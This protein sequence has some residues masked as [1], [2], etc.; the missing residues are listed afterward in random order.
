MRG[1]CLLERV[2]DWGS[3]QLAA[4]SNLKFL[5]GRIVHLESRPR[6]QVPPPLSYACRM[7]VI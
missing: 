4:Q 3:G 2:L 7:P 1:V 5:P 6:S